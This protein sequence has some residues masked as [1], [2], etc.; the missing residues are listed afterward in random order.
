MHLLAVG[1]SQMEYQSNTDY[2]SSSF[3]K[4][5]GYVRT[6]KQ[7]NSTFINIDNPIF[8]R[9][10]KTNLT[11]KIRKEMLQTDIQNNI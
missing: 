4:K 1:Q 7:T 8:H 2:K 3:Y 10:A 5:K 11:K 6:N 9:Y